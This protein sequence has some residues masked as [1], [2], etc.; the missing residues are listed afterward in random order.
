MPL[1]KQKTS[2]RRPARGWCSLPRSSPVLLLLN[3]D[4]ALNLGIRLV[5]RDPMV[6]EP[7]DGTDGARFAEL[8]W[9]GIVEGSGAVQLEG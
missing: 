9:M 6:V 8:F 5:F 4:A 2:G 3:H 7:C 1:E